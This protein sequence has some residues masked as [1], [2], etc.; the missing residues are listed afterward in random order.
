MVESLFVE[1]IRVPEYEEGSQTGTSINLVEEI[2]NKY[3]IKDLIDLS[4]DKVVNV[5][6]VL[7][8]CLYTIFSEFED[9]ETEALRLEKLQS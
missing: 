8:E 4:K 5:R 7:S 6:I 1:F 3:F 9:L 2:I